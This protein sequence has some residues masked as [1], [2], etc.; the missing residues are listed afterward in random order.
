MARFKNKKIDFDQA[1]VPSDV[2]EH[3]LYWEVDVAPDYDSAFLGFTVDLDPEIPTDLPGF[4]VGEV[5]YVGVSA[6]N[7]DGHESDMGM[8][9]DPFVFIAPPVPIFQVVDA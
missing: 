2:V 7:L 5:V 3:R 8:I 4:P 6:I 9:T 1:S